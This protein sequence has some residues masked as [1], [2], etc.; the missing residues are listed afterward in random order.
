MIPISV[1]IITKNEA[2]KLEKCL[3]CISRYPFEIVVVDT[4]SSDNTLEVIQRYTQNCYYFKWINDFSAARNY[5]ISKA[6]NDWILSL[7][8]DEYIT[9]LNLED[10]YSL[11]EENPS[12]LGHLEIRSLDS[13]ASSFVINRLARL[14]RRDLYH[15]E[16]P[17]HEQLVPIH[18]NIT[19]KNFMIPLHV[20]HDG[21]VGT[22]EQ[23]AIKAKRNLD[24]L[25]TCANDYPDAY[26]YYQIGQSYSMMKNWEKACEYFEIGLSFDLD[27]QADY[28]QFMIINYGYMLIRLNRLQDAVLFFE[29]LYDL[30]SDLAD[31]VFL[32][33]FIY[34]NTKDYLKAAL[35]FIRATTL[36]KYLVEGCNGRSAYYYLGLIYA[37]LGSTEIA[38][39]FLLRCGDFEPAVTALSKIDSIAQTTEL[40]QEME[41]TIKNSEPF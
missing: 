20:E 37:S 25:L 23:L 28:V 41:A 38:R 3:S 2:V 31:Y 36:T 11:M 30:Y 5:A 35:Q 8:S 21:Y 26:T 19:R 9:D 1:C 14:F 29:K 17:I 13:N 12:G 15:F 10:L 24:L 7:D 40:T 32:L 39:D 22:P 33:G 16:R 6:S 4:G 27:P 34:M 18:N